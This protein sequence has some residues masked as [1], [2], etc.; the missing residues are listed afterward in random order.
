M[1]KRG[2]GE[3][4]VY[5][6][7]DGRWVAA[8]TLP[9]HMGGKK[10]THY[11]KTRKECIEWLD[12]TRHSIKSGKYI[13]NSDISV[14]KWLVT[15]LNEY[16]INIRPSTRMNYDT[17]IN[18]H[19]GSSR[20]AS[21]PLNMVNVHTLQ[22]YLNDLLQNGRL[23][24]NGG[25]SPKTI[26]N[27]YNML[28]KAMKQAVG[29]KL[30]LSNPA[31]HV[32]LPKIIK[33]SV[34]TLDLQEQKQLVEACRGERWTIAVLLSLGT[35]L[36]IGELLALRHSDVL[37]SDN[38]PYLNISKSLQRVKDYCGETDG[39]S[40]VLHESSTKTENSVRQIPISPT[41]ADALKKHI[42]HQKSDAKKSY[43]LYNN[44]PYIISNELGE[45]IDP[46]TYRKW[47]K[48]ITEKAGLSGRVTPHTLRHSFAS[49]A[50]KYG[51]NLKN[52]SD[53]LGHYSTDFTARTYIHTDLKGKYDAILSMD[54]AIKSEERK[55]DNEYTLLS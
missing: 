39:H 27:L 50:L 22:T 44:N 54:K 15:W 28:N 53:I 47:F 12:E 24:G 8:L 42:S 55:D 7:K 6:R 2:N 34:R 33:S 23:D 49:S 48:T 36:R 46:G 14:K 11:G 32:I 37:I 9:S 51:M 16:C 5:R 38:I 30:I 52:I 41:L 21:L 18:R 19:I 20:I 40:T 13:I 17:Y 43:G 29:N 35:G 45:C 3:G 25:L 10:K 1:A 31:D 4:S 26:R